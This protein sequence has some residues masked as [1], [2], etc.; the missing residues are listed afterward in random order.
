MPNITGSTGD[1]TGNPGNF[2]TPPT[3]NVFSTYHENHR[4]AT[5][6]GGD[7]GWRTITFDASRSS[8]IYKN[9]GHVVPNSIEQSI[10]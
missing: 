3:N 1:L 6:G 10:L 8:S 2:S 9:N 4:W 5:G 7:L